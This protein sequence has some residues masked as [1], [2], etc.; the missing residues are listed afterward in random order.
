MQETQKLYPHLRAHRRGCCKSAGLKTS[1]QIGQSGSCSIIGLVCELDEGMDQAVEGYRADVS[2]QSALG[3]F[4]RYEKQ[5]SQTRKRAS[6]ILAIR[7]VLYSIVLYDYNGE[8]CV[9]K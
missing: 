5:R 6:L 1:R 4:M 8:V 2:R 3:L 9:Y 7:K